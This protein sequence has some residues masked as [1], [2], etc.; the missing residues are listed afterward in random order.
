MKR[1]YLFEDVRLAKLPVRYSDKLAETIEDIKFYNRFEEESLKQWLNELKGL[2]SWLSNP[3]IAWDNHNDFIHFDNGETYIE[4]CGILFK[5]LTDKNGQ[6]IE[7]NF[8]FVIDI[9]LTPQDY[10][11]NV[12]PYINENKKYNTMKNTKN[13]V[14]LTESQLHNVINESVKQVLSELN[15]KTLYNAEKKAYE[16][17][18][19]ADNFNKGTRYYNLIPKLRKARQKAFNDEYGYDEGNGGGSYKM[20]I[21]GEPMDTYPFM[22]H[23]KVHTQAR[24]NDRGYEGPNHRLDYGY[25]D[26]DD[27]RFPS[28]TFDLNYHGDE[29]YDMLGKAGEYA[30]KGN[31]EIENYRQGNYEYEPNGRGW[32]LKDNI[33][34]SIRRA[35]REV[36]R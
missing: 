7:R 26:E 25:N 15:W 1:F 34:E 19:N 2:V 17:W 31:K 14:R 36:L 28:G 30:K 22:P 20:K 4:R 23:K 24:T 11:L 8:V 13:M 3:V 12:P 35:I 10:N 32:H 33:D 18:K 6:G 5:A 16:K 9:V 21:D 29:Y 27:V